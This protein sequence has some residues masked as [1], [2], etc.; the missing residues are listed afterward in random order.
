M[1][2]RPSTFGSRM[3]FTTTRVQDC[4]HA[5]A[6]RQLFLV[7]ARA[8]GWG[9][10]GY[11]CCDVASWPTSSAEV[12][13]SSYC[14]QH[15]HDSHSRAK[16]SSSSSSTRSHRIIPGDAATGPAALRFP[17]EVAATCYR[18]R[19]RPRCPRPGAASP[20]D[21]T[22]TSTNQATTSADATGI[23]QYNGILKHFIRRCIH[24]VR[25]H[26]QE[27]ASDLGQTKRGLLY[28][29][30]AAFRR[31]FGE[32]L[33]HFRPP[34]RFIGRSPDCEEADCQRP[35]PVRIPDIAPKRGR[36][37]LWAGRLGW[38]HLPITD[39]RVRPGKLGLG[40]VSPDRQELRTLIRAV[41]LIA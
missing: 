16:D 35:T 2:F 19:P 32:P 5:K 30:R 33:G 7:R 9:G 14:T 34:M 36:I 29:G 18:S 24:A 3:T 10:R 12:G 40:T 6:R 25:V 13:S 39:C 41:C 1:P 15:P 31:D 38:V 28:R 11:A 4:E 22:L 27:H 26:F 21:A 23:A 17:T 20:H 37:G 8:G